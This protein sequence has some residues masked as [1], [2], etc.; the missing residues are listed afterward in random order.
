MRPQE[1]PMKWML[2]GITS[3]WSPYGCKWAVS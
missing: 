2:D 1:T 3:L